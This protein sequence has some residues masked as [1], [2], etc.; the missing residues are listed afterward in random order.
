MSVLTFMY[1][2]VG[3]LVGSAIT[4]GKSVVSG[5]TVVRV[6]LLFLIASILANSQ[7]GATLLGRRL[8]NAEVGSFFGGLISCLYVVMF[9]VLIFVLAR[10]SYYLGIIT[11]DTVQEFSASCKLGDGKF[12]KVSEDESKTANKL[13]G[14]LFILSINLICSTLVGIGLIPD[15]FLVGFIFL[16]LLSIYLAHRYIKKHGLDGLSSIDVRDRYESISSGS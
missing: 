13:I 9:M 10:M 6:N 2:F 16:G 11:F 12:V 14:L 1:L 4:Y 15:E 3:C 7:L 5:R 8:F